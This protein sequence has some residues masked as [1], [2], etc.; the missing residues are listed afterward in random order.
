MVCSRIWS[1]TCTFLHTVMVA[2][3][4]TLNIS[5][6]P[7]PYAMATDE[8]PGICLPSVRPYREMPSDDASR[9][10]YGG[11]SVVNTTSYPMLLESQIELPILLS[12]HP[13]ML[14]SP[15][16]DRHPLMVRHKLQL[17]VWKLSGDDTKRAD[18]RR[19]FRNH[20]IWMEQRN[21]RGLPVS[22]E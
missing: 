22:M 7:D 13:D 10:S 19:G 9:E 11:S 20:C 3:R 4:T 12:M 15:F 21:Q 17:A 6:R 14:K 8:Y 18:F 1:I 16:D 5:W 2:V